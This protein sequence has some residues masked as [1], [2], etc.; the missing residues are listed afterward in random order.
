MRSQLYTGCAPKQITS[1]TVM[2]N[3]QKVISLEESDAAP[4][5]AFWEAKERKLESRA[6]RMA[7]RNGLLLRKSRLSGEIPHRYCVVE[8]SGNL[9]VINALYIETVLNFLS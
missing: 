1:D 8:P 5:V 3:V 2:N 4:D 6:T 9:L 7:K